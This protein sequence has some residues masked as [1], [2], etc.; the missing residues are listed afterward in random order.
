MYN[1]KGG[2]AIARTIELLGI[3]MSES[4]IVRR[5]TMSV[6][7][8]GILYDITNPGLMFKFARDKSWVKR[9]IDGYWKSNSSN[10]EPNE[11]KT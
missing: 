1:W 4:P 2:D 11:K 7:G 8:W 3:S 9:V 5:M 6:L 10:D